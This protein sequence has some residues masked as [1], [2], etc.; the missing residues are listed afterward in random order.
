M[1]FL[2]IEFRLLLV[3]VRPI[4]PFIAFKIGLDDFLEVLFEPF[5]WLSVAR[6]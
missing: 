2:L 6:A 1:F 5:D 3:K 4:F